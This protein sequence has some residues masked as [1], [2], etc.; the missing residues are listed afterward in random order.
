MVWNVKVNGTYII[1][2]MTVE[3]ITRTNSICSCF[4][5]FKI[6]LFQLFFDD[7]SC[8]FEKK[9]IRFVIE[10]CELATI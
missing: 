8:D 7:K 6:C 1:L 2:S 9:S 3:K 5:S 10:N 4:F